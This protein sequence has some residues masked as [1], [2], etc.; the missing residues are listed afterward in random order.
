MASKVVKISKELY[1]KVKAIADSRGVTMAKALE[2]LVEDKPLPEEVEAFVPS[3][4]EELGVRMP[5]NYGWIKV[6]AEVLPAGLR[7]KLEPYAKVL[8]CAEAKAELKKLAEEH[9]EQVEAVTEAEVIPMLKSSS[10]LNQ[11][12]KTIW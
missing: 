2:N 5:A 3:C 9:L 7:G 8:E 10:V 6:L 12:E 1:D 11:N 4:A